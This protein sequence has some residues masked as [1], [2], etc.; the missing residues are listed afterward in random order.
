MNKAK[1]LVVEDETKVSLDIMKTLR[2]LGYQVMGTV[3]SGKKAI[4]F[5]KK[6]KPDLILMD[7]GLKGEMD[8]IQTAAQ[9]RS[10]FNIP[11][12]Y[13]MDCTDD[14]TLERAKVTAPCGYLPKPFQEKDLRIAIRVG[15]YQVSLESERNALINNLQNEINRRIE[16]TGM[17][18]HELKNSLTS[19][20][21]SSEL[22]SQQLHDKPGGTLAVNIYRSTKQMYNRVREMLDMAKIEMGLLR[23]KPMPVQPREILE[24][25]LE[26]IKPLALSRRQSVKLEL[27]RSLPAIWADSD[28]L[29]QIV[30]NLLD[31]GSKFMSEGGT[32]TIGAVEQAPYLM[33]FVRDTGRGMSQEKV[34]RLFAQDYRFEDDEQ[35]SSGLGLGL[36]LCKNLVEAHGGRIWVESKEGEGSTF[37]FTIPLAPLDTQ[38]EG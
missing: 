28:R 17:V 26:D 2:N 16:F 5:V 9:I 8:G 3:P 38:R 32:I 1:I 34:S 21:A 11:V 36:V 4:E 33:V 22:L 18:A 10:D 23:I 14:E 7:I 20:M 19:L 35:P 15:L 30:A 27:P 29:W 25:L 37:Y 24:K 6:D 31:N 12:I 13:L